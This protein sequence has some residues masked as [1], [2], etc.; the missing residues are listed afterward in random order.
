MG[1]LKTLTG[2]ASTA[3]GAISGAVG[4]PLDALTKLWHYITSVHGMMSWLAGN[5]FLRF[6]KTALENLTTIGLALQVI[7]D[8]LHRVGG[9]IWAHEVRPVRDQLQRKITALRAWAVVEFGR[10]WALIQV[11]YLQA[12]AFTVKQVAAERAQRIKAVQA[13]HAAMLA[14][15][16]ATLATVQKQAAGAYNAGVHAR[17]G[18]AGQL[19][20]DLVTR[21]PLIK[22]LVNAVIDGALK[23]ADVEDPVLGFLLTKLVNEIVSKVGVDRLAAEA[24]QSLLAPVIGGKRPA[25]LHD[26]V[27]DID[28]RLTAMEKQWADFMKKGGPEVE[29]AGEQWKGLTGLAADAGMLAFVG[30]AVAEPAAW[31]QGISDTVGVAGDAALTAAVSLI[32]KL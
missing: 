12:L 31:A 14:G 16:K 21:T 24:A 18:I 3:W 4:N 7:R 9:W 8:V 22:D 17:V 29:D 15:D 13:E 26:V 6:F 25:G 20:D 30:L 1:F 19:L 5:P 23:L 11:R 28:A 2:W 27:A 10:T 32:G